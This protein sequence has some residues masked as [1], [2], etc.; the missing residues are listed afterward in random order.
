MDNKILSVCVRCGKQ[1][2]LR[3]VREETVG[4]STVVITEAICPDRL[5]Q[6]KVSRML[7]D[8]HGRRMQSE[9]L[10]QER[11]AGRKDSKLSGRFGKSQLD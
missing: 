7:E 3:S 9:V 1:R 8:E 6:Q 4:T 10:R 11:I 2:I 5:C